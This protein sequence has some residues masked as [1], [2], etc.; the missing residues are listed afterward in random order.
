MTTELVG[1]LGGM[2]F[3][4]G[5]VLV[6]SGRWNG[7]SFWYEI[8]N[9]LGSILLL[10]Y[11]I[12]KLAYTNI[13]LNLVWGIVAMYTIYHIVDRHQKRKKVIKKGK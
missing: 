3:L 4:I 8:A 13:V 12:Q 2:M 7:R 5:F 10:Y 11:S 1:I 9:F 6:S